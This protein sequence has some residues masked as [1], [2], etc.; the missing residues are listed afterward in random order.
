MESSSRPGSPRV[1][2]RPL[3]ASDVARVDRLL[4]RLTAYSLAVGGVPKERDG[5]SRLLSETPPGR[6]A[7][8]KKTVEVTLDQEPIGL[9]DL[10]EGYPR[11][12]VTFIGLLAIVEDRHGLG[13]GRAAFEAV[14]AYARERLNARALRLAFVDTNPVEGFWQKMGFRRT[15]EV[16]PYEGEARSG[17]AILI[18]KDLLADA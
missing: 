2:L 11:D 15:G 9:A 13:L 18:E 16:R 17:L 10:V 8:A 4:D 14:E 12:G 7:A 5:A 3:N 6:D 1:S